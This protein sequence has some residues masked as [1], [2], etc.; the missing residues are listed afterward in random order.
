MIFIQLW[1]GY[2]SREA[3]KVLAIGEEVRDDNMHV[4]ATLVVLQGSVPS[5][6]KMRSL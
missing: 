2:I 6:L 4:S 3:E 1:I 5:S